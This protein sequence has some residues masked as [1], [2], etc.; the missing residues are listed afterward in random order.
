MPCSP[1]NMALVGFQSP[2]RH[3]RCRDCREEPALAG[4]PVLS[5]AQMK[6]LARDARQGA[7]FTMHSGE[8]EGYPMALLMFGGMASAG[9]V[10]RSAW[11]APALAPAEPGN[12]NAAQE[13]RGAAARCDVCGK[14]PEDVERERLYRCSRCASV[15]YCRWGALR[16]EG[17][18]QL[19]RAQL[20]CAGSLAVR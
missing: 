3:A 14:L 15:K 4:F 11:A 17:P 10:R 2:G 19:T 1:D 20:D 7:Q 6:E 8:G 18:M 13:G 12:G 9:E 5:S 16:V